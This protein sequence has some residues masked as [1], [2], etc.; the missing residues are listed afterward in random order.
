MRF[1][2]LMCQRELEGVGWAK[3]PAT[4]H[5]HTAH[6]GLVSALRRDPNWVQRANQLTGKYAGAQGKKGE[7]MSTFAGHWRAVSGWKYL[8]DRRLGER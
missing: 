7:L 1:L 4:T 3:R 5:F 8:G 6:P 2:N